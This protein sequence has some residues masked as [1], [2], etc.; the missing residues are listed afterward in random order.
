[1]RSLRTIHII[2]AHAE[3]EVGDVI[4]GG[5]EPPPGDTREQRNYIAHNQEQLRSR[6]GVFRHVNIVAK[7]MSGSNSICTVLLESGIL[8]MQERPKWRW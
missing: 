1:M 2:S 8:P 6:G 3:W 4:V 5:V 7:L